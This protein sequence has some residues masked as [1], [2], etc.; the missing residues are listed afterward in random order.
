MS[1]VHQNN[2]GKNEKIYPQEYL[3]VKDHFVNFQ[4]CLM[5]SDGVIWVCVICCA[6][7]VHLETTCAFLSSPS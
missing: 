6:S 7:R 2:A 1:K 4:A 3:H 5:V